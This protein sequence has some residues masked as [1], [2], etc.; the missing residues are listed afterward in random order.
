[1][2]VSDDGRQPIESLLEE[3]QFVSDSQFESETTAR[4]QEERSGRFFQT[5]GAALGRGGV[6]AAV[7]FLWFK[8]RK[9]RQENQ[10]SL[11]ENQSDE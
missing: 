9:R 4:K 8:L 1:M 6:V 2:S 5:L 3:Q 7:I 10:A 11:S